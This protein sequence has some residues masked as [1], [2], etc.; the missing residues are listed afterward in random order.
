[1]PCQLSGRKPIK[2]RK[3]LVAFF[4]LWLSSSWIDGGLEGSSSDSKK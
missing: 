2:E 4:M 1:M 3:L